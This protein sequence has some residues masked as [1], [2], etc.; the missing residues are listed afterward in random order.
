MMI[1]ISV[2]RK[3]PI[4]GLSSEKLL[5]YELDLVEFPYFKAAVIS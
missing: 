2:S 4:K 1:P 3:R 5:F